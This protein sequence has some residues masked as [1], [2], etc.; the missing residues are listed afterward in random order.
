MRQ[1]IDFEARAS[2][3]DLARTS[4]EE[5]REALA[6]F[7][8]AARQAYELLG[9]SADVMASAGRELHEKA[10]QHADEHLRLSFELAQCLAEARIS[11]GRSLF[12]ASSPGKQQKSISGRFRSFHAS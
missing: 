1:P 4:L 9:Q 7:I 8:E 11:K 5:A 6:R 2:L 10:V 3:H 12:K